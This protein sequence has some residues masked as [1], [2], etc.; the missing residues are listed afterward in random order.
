[1]GLTFVF[2]FFIGYG[3]RFSCSTFTL[4]VNFLFEIDQMF[5]VHL[6]LAKSIE[7]GNPLSS[8]SHDLNLTSFSNHIAYRYDIVMVAKR[9]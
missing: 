4:K 9:Y 7:S 1:M 3:N 2:P 5:G 6:V 8:N